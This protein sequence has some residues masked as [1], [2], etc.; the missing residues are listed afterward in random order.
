MQKS[1][2]LMTSLSW[3]TLK[4][5]STHRCSVKRTTSTKD[6]TNGIIQDALLNAKLRLMNISNNTKKTFKKLGNPQR[7]DQS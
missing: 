5:Y 7:I 3:F 6:C 4:W 2:F 1:L